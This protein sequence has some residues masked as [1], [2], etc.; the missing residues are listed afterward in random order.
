MLF[1]EGFKSKEVAEQMG[2]TP[3]AITQRYNRMMHDVVIPYFKRYFVA[4]EYE[5]SVY[6]A[7]DA[8]NCMPCM[9]KM[10]IDADFAEPSEYNNMDNM[11]QGRITPEWIDSL[12]DNEVF[13]FGSNLAGM[14]GGGAARVAHLRF[15]AV[16]GKGVGLQGQSYAIPTMQGGV[17]TIRPY[18]N[19][20]IAF[21]KANPEKHF[22]VT[23]IGC[24][25]A[26]FEPE[27]IA[28]LFESAKT[29]NNIS[30]PESFWE[31]IE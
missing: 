9:A 13:V 18:V 8:K 29:I 5:S 26:G 23:P 20:F 2:M 22:L 6:A 10:S 27:D 17:E 3:S 24:G 30:L 12:K 19:D 4:S 15:G 25:I 28:P 16:L 11:K 7:I 1:I 21:A 31:V 14:H